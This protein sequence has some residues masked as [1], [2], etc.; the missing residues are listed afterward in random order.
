MQT[1]IQQKP[2]KIVLSNKWMR[3]AGTAGFSF[4]LVKGLV[5]IVVAVWAIY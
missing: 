3:R 1:T 5:W 4:F 2:Q